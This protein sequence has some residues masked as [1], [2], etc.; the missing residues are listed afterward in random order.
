MGL[1]IICFLKIFYNV[2][3]RFDDN[4]SAENVTRRAKRNGL[5]SFVP[6]EQN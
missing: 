4:S 2:F 3:F 1:I 6:A 5:K